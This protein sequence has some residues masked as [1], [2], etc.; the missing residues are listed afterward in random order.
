[1]AA[2]I[3]ICMPSKKALQRERDKLT[4]MTNSHQCHKPIP[5]LIEELNRQLKGW[6]NYFKL[7]YPRDAFREINWH[8]GHRLFRNLNRRSQ[9]AFRLP[10]GTTY[11]QNFLRLVLHPSAL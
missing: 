3:G 7:G 11:Y 6:G 8:V 1:M 4:E 10:E 2:A 5:Q 9:R